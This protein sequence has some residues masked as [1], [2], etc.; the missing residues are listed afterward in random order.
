MS[1][2]EMIEKI[3]MDE[4]YVGVQYNFCPKCGA[5]MSV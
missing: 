4:F 5:E 3:I 2:I 1:K